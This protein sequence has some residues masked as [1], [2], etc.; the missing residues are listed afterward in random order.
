MGAG[1]SVL[2]HAKPIM[3]GLV[4]RLGETDMRIMMQFVLISLVILPV[5]LDRS[6]G[7]FGVLNPREIWWMV[8]LVVGISLVGYIALKLYGDPTG[9]I[10]A[11]LVLLASTVVYGRVLLEVFIAAPRSLADVAPPVVLM[12][13]AS[14]S[15]RAS[16]V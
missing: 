14:T 12:L 7:P 13:L 2:L 11:G 15:R 10:L 9:L 16:P 4:K 8:V 1:V 5:L 3:H 6:Y